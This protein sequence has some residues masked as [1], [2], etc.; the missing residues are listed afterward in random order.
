MIATV[1]R[2]HLEEEVE[3]TQGDLPGDEEVGVVGVEAVVM[4]VGVVL[5]VVFGVVVGRPP[6]AKRVM[7]P[8]GAVVEVV[9]GVMEQ[10]DRTTMMTRTMV[11]IKDLVI[12]T[13]PLPNLLSRT[14]LGNKI[15]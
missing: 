7:G 14:I 4:V 2:I 1:H 10:K 11:S 8:A 12:I 6:L 13:H 3:V 5:E 15:L 9:V